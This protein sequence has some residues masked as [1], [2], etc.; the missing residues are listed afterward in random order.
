M[1]GRRV[2]GAGVIA[3][4]LVP[5][6][7]VWV[8]GA[9]AVLV[10]ALGACKGPEVPSP[11]TNQSR[12]T[13]CNMHYEKSEMSDVNYQ[14]GTLLPL[15]TRVQILEVGR[16]RVK[17]QPEGQQ[18]LVLVLKYGRDKIPF[19]RY[20]DEVFVTD[21]PR[22]RLRKVSP[23]VRKLIEQASVEPGMQRDEVVMA[24][25]YPPAHRTPSL[26]QMDWHYWENRWHQ[27]VVFFDGQKV[28]RVQQ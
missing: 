19:D 16:N 26:E 6:R 2:W 4:L 17:F 11:L 13:C 15:G 5:G 9:I 28:D 23:K 14:Q 18:P 1:T 21:D 7:R 20:L 22:A 27:F 3:V 24:L 10:L 25:G 12:F 8:A